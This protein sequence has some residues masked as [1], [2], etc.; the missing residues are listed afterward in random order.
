MKR[1][2]TMNECRC[3]KSENRDDRLTFSMNND[4]ENELEMSKSHEKKLMSKSLTNMTSSF[5]MSTKLHRDV[6]RMNKE[7][8]RQKNER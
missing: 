6:V 2:Q 8:M 1:T 4:E 5:R 3:K 7:Y